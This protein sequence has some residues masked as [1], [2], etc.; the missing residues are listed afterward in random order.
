MEKL[1][2]AW[3]LV[4]RGCPS[5]HSSPSSLLCLV[6]QDSFLG[7]CYC[8]S[9]AQ[10]CPILCDPMDCSM[11]GLPGPHHLLEYAQVRVH[12]IGDAVQPSNPLMPSSPSA[13]NHSQ[14]QGLPMS[15]LFS[16][17][18]QNT[19]ASASASVLPMRIQ[20]F[21]LRLTGSISL[22]SKGLSGVFSST[23]VQRH[24][25]LGTLSFLP[26]SSHNHMWPLE[27]S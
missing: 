12:C 4:I 18:D 22:P 11:S 7:S 3:T 10:S 1:C 8:C 9:V 5:G 6:W 2:R 25:F 13:L 23:T 15:R 24:Q 19:E 27:R 20:W 14:H 16:S 21:P 26:S 17:S